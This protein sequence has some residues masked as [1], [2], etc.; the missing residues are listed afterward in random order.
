M[1]RGGE[2]DYIGASK[3]DVDCCRL[4]VSELLASGMEVSNLHVAIPLIAC[5]GFGI[6][7]R[8]FGLGVQNRRRLVRYR[9]IDG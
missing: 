9:T 6:P 2:V 3:A 5:A 8:V 7:V 4:L 1:W